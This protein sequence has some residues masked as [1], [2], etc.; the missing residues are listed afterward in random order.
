M[1]PDRHRPLG[2]IARVSTGP[3][4]LRVLVIVPA[5][6]EQ[7]SIAAT[8]R[9]IHACV[10]WADLLVVDDGSA[11]RTADVAVAA[12][13]GAAEAGASS[14]PRPIVDSATT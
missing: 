9:E 13:E 11:D 2:S 4:G 10:P 1:G 3:Q 8:L 14:P 7:A 5:W 12:S 6:N